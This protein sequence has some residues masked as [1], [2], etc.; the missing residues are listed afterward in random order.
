[1]RIKLNII[2]EYKKRE[3]KNRSIFLR[4]MRWNFEFFA[5]YALF[6]V[7]LFAVSYILELNLQANLI[8]LNPNNI[9][10][11]DEF[12]IYDKKIKETND[13]VAEIRK[14]Q[15]GQIYWTKLFSRLEGLLPEGVFITEIVSKDYSILLAGYS[16]NRDNLSAFRD[17]ILNEK[18]SNDKNCFTEVDLPLSYLSVKENLDFQITFSVE[19]ECLK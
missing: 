2:P 12:K 4:I 8:Q 6:I 10:K 19:K 1:M 18:N 17:K 14:I 5:V 11:F 9:S 13:N 3:I 7:T 15:E 16:N